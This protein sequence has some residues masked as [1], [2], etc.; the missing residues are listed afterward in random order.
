MPLLQLAYRHR[1]NNLVL[2]SKTGIHYGIERIM[3]DLKLEGTA[4][5]FRHTWASHAAMRGISMEEIAGV[6]GDT[7]KTVE[8]N[9]LH[10]SPDYLRSAI[11]R[12]PS[13]N[14]KL[15]NAI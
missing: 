8:K 4:H 15:Q 7:I 10:L 2:D 1:K 12:K 11:N 13:Q 5:K 14:V 3:D 6:L 9:Y